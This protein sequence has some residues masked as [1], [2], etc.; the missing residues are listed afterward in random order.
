MGA[1]LKSSAVLALKMKGA[2]FPLCPLSHV[3]YLYVP[4]HIESFSAEMPIQSC[5]KPVTG[6]SDW[7]PNVEFKALLQRITK[8]FFDFYATAPLQILEA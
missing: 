2:N 4:H 8:G 1:H 5:K 3:P 6:F 7:Q